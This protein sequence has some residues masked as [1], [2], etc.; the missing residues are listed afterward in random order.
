MEERRIQSEFGWASGLGIQATFCRSGRASQM[1]AQDDEKRFEE[2]GDPKL[3]QSGFV[4]FPITWLK[5]QNPD[6]EAF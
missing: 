4:P 5:V 3:R 1:D 2:K 6:I